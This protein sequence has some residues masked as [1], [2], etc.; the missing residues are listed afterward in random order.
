[1]ALAILKQ[2]M[3]DLLTE[4]SRS[5]SATLLVGAGASYSLGLPT[6]YGLIMD[7]GE[8]HL[9]LLQSL[10]VLDK[11]HEGKS[12]VH[13][14]SREEFA[15]CLSGLFGHSIDLRRALTDWMTMKMEDLTSDV[16]ATLVICWLQGLFRHLV[17]TNWD[18]ALENQVDRLYDLA[19]SA[20][21]VTDPIR[22]KLDSGKECSILPDRLFY[23]DD[24]SSLC[25]RWDI[26]SDAESVASL[27]V[28]SRPIW[29][30]HGSP[31][32]LY[33]PECGALS[34]WKRSTDL[35]IGDCCP[36][37][38]DRRLEPEMIFWKNGLDKERPRVWH[39]LRDRI[40]RSDMLV[41]VGFSGWDTY[42]RDQFRRHRNAWLVDPEINQWER[43]GGTR[44]IGVRHV[45]A[46]ASDFA[47]ALVPLCN[48]QK[49]VPG[50]WL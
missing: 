39:K 9:D 37:H 44:Q 40:R 20:P 30:I 28:C 16:Q 25:P 45:S 31:F 38:P 12:E 32:L 43:K 1:M 35:H 5:Q 15:D 34:R 49:A 42:I 13:K 22:L 18:F 2:S 17:T 11:W 36:N 6:G 24:I 21:E 47:T 4:L 29:K 26:V 14:N 8:H 23:I 50:L 10:G 41:A 33:C 27:R 48:T 46:Y 19:Y 7:F 3:G